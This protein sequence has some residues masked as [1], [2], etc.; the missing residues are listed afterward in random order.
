MTCNFLN[1]YFTDRPI[2]P[3]KQHFEESH[4]LKKLITK[5]LNKSVEEEM[6]SRASG[7]KN[8]SKV[9]QAVAAHNSKK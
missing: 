6:R 3:K 5:T 7:N 9:Q 8:L 4:K 2:K 1:I